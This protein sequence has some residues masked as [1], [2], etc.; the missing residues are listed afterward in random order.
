MAINTTVAAITPSRIKAAAFGND[1]S[2]VN[3]F[4]FPRTLCRRETPPSPGSIINPDQQ[5]LLILLL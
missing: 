1:V 2:C 5:L 4:P 3:P